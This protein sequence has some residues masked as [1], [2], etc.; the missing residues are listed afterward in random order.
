MSSSKD[1]ISLARRRSRAR[2]VTAI[3]LAAAL[4]GGCAARARDPLVPP[5]V[6]DARERATRSLQSDLA[7]LF[8]DP[9]L[10]RGT[11]AV[12]VE[13]LDRGGV[14]FRYNDESRM[15][16]A[17]NQKLLTLAAAG[18]LLGWEYRF[19]TTIH[20]MGPI[21]EG[22]LEG[23]LVVVGS[24]DPSLSDRY[25]GI[26]PVFA[27][28]AEKVRAAGV[29]TITGRLL[30][31]A[32]AMAGPPWGAGWAWDNLQF[33]YAAPIAALQ[34]GD[35]AAAVTVVAGP[36]PGAPAGVTLS[37]PRSG[38]TVEGR[39]MTVAAGAPMVLRFERLPGTVRLDVSGEIAVGDQ[40]TRAVS[41]ADPV[42][43]FLTALSEVFAAHGIEIGRGIDIQPEPGDIA[44]LPVPLVRH[45]SPP[46]RELAATA[47]RT[48][49]NLHAESLFRALARVDMR[50]GTVEDTRRSIDD[51]LKRWGVPA[52][53][54]V[55]A[56]G[57][58]LSRDNF[59]TAS[60]VMAVLRRMATGDRHRDEW[61]ALFP[62]GGHEGTLSRRFGGG[63]AAGRVRAKTGTLSAVKALSG[64]VRTVGGELLAFVMIVNNAAGTRQEVEGVLD[65]AV[66][67]L[68][69]FER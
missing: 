12:R 10:R 63:A 66:E 2:R 39:V 7:V 61:L 30:A 34:A 32:R 33:G 42:R 60:A 69:S 47:M 45:E 13:S 21:R 36:E 9:A 57:S 19:V 4:G 62:A 43:H 20:P 15:L 28:W 17:S 59:V 53:A 18:E 8:S 38:L 6:I 1:S 51:L 40:V 52:D 65:R 11:V 35:N 48:S 55:V 14:L 31:D 68:A 25:A 22:V 64:Y 24:G 54:V 67:R 46:L 56:D 37:D 49:H 44:T 23:D 41:V 29:T 58:G 3:V 50:A 26:G 27:G 16:P 5:S